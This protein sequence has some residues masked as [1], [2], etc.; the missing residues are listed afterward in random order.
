MIVFTRNTL[1][2]SRASLKVEC[3]YN[4][5]RRVMD[6][7]HKDEKEPRKIKQTSTEEE[8]KGEREG[9]RMKT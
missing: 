7:I 9:E 5:K 2:H 6:A 3:I 4:N 8:E 1:E